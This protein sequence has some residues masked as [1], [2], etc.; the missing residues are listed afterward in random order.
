[1]TI[2]QCRQWGT[3][4][5]T[6]SSPTPQLDTSCIL[7]DILKCD[8]TMLLLNHKEEVAENQL[9]S[10]QSAIQKRKTG[11][12]VAYITKHK[13]FYGY[14]FFVTPDVL[15]PKP[16]TEILV[17]N[18]I[19][20]F[21]NLSDSTPKTICDMCSGSGCIG[22]SVM[23]FFSTDYP[24]KIKNTS[25]V[26]GDI[27]SKALSITQK[28]AKRLIP[29]INNQLSFFETN[30][31]E[32]IPSELSFDMILTNPPYIPSQMVDE[33]L[34][35]GRNEPRLALDGDLNPALNDKEKSVDG[36]GLIRKLI[37]EIKERLKPGAVFF[38]ETGEYN[39][40]ETA[41]L[42]KKYGFCNVEIIKD[43]ENQNRVVTGFAPL[44]N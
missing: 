3:K 10:F 42:F 41:D 34:T 36:L 5:L 22:I 6:D 1:M 37:P 19:K 35:D 4:E 15:I 24:E 30:L 25:L 21:Y 17:E 8:K 20:Y 14:D 12:P 2:A 39:A 9:K 23:K 29:E 38:M 26:F 7:C 43:L 27:S 40:V 31:F 28:N 18:A 32:N 44:G 13:E 33:L 16:D 11:L